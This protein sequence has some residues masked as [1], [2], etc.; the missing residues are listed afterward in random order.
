MTDETRDEQMDNEDTEDGPEETRTVS[1]AVVDLIPPGEV[2]PVKFLR[3]DGKAYRLPSDLFRVMIS[4]LITMAPTC[5]SEAMEQTRD[6]TVLVKA[7]AALAFL[8]RS[9]RAE[10][11]HGLAKVIAEEVGRYS[12]A[13]QGARELYAQLV[14]LETWMNMLYGPIA[15]LFLCA[16]HEYVADAQ[17]VLGSQYADEDSE[18][19]GADIEAV[20]DALRES[21]ASGNRALGHH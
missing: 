7:T 12:D 2:T 9:A 20:L 13:R 5:G 21:I 8:S 6:E 4:R 15:R 3:V 10:T 17:T 1:V 18:E 11:E 19:P 16:Q 14:A